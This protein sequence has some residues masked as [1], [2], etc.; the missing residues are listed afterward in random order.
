MGM[1][2]GLIA[3]DVP[4]ERLLAAINQHA[5]ELRPGPTHASLDEMDLEPKDEGW[6]MAMGERGGHAFILDTSLVLSA[7]H[8]LM[9]ALS[10]D[11]G[12][13]TVVGAGAETTSGSYWLF[14]A[15]QGE[16]VRSYWNSYTDMR[17]PWSRGEPLPTEAEQPLEDLDGDGL[18]AAVES[19]GLDYDGWVQAGPYQ[20]VFYTADTFPDDGPHTAEFKAFYDSVK[21]PEGER[22]QPTVVTREAGGYDLVPGG[23]PQAGPE[24][25]KK[26]GLFGLFKR[27]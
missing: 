5:S 22:P 6:P 18:M 14:A 1:H 13:A 24:R 17:E 23:S 25:V 4:L 27:R 19:L 3:A 15:R 26:R 2:H 7:A 9:P 8:D 12:G 11:L 16:A 21:I 10:R 20:A